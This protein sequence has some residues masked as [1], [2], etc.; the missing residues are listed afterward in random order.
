[1]E[2]KNKLQKLINSSKTLNKKQ[3]EEFLKLIDKISSEDT[4]K[5]IAY[6]KILEAKAERLI[7]KQ[8]ALKQ[9]AKNMKSIH[10]KAKVKAITIVEKKINQSKEAE[11]DSILKREDLKE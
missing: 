9:H 11:L 4:E 3:K 7:E 10:A 2:A 6:L 1:M 5:T 8:K